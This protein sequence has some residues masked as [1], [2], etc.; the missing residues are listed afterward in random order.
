MIMKLKLTE[1]APNI[2]SAKY[3]HT[4]N[5]WLLLGL[6]FIT[7]VLFLTT[8]F[9]FRKEV[10]KSEKDANLFRIGLAVMGIIFGILIIM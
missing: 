6:L 3:V 2:F 8:V 1:V 10:I 5:D 9:Y 4:M 7:A